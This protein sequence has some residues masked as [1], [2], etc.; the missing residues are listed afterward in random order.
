MSNAHD[1]RLTE[2]IAVLGGKAFLL[3]TA[4]HR[5]DALFSG[6]DLVQET[7]P[8][9]VD[10]KEMTM[11]INPDFNDRFADITATTSPL[12]GVASSTAVR[13]YYQKLLR[14]IA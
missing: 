2:L 6:T 11:A 3:L 9:P 14:G 5:C 4:E 10:K 12:R 7:S 13:S 1:M 8:L